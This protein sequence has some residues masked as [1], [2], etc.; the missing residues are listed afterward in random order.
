[1]KIAVIGGGSTYMPELMEG[2]LKH[3]NKMDL[4]EVYLLDLKDSTKFKTVAELCIRMVEKA[5]NPFELKYGYESA[6]ALTDADFI[7]Q[8]YRP[9]L[10]E[11]RINDEKIPLKYSSIGQ[12]T[13]GA[14]GF[15]CGLRG[16]PVV[17]KYIEAIRKWAKPNAKVINF[18]NPSGMISE[19]AIH[20]LEYENFYGLCN[21]PVNMIQGIAESFNT[22]REAV[23][24]RYYG[25][26][27]M[28]WVDGVWVNGE[29]ITG[30]ALKEVYKPEN[31]PE[32]A[33]FEEL[34][35]EMQMILN[36]Y[37]R[38]YYLTRE[39]LKEEIESA[40]EKGTRGEQVREIEKELVAKYSR[41]DLDKKPEE[42]SQRGGSMYS[43]A[44][45][46]L[47][48][49]LC[50]NDNRLHIINTKNNGAV[51]NLP[52]DYVLEIN[53]VVSKDAAKPVTIGKADKRTTGLIHTIKNF[54]RLTIES[55]TQNSTTKAKQALM[56][57]PLAPK[58]KELDE[59]IKDLLDS[60]SKLMKN[61]S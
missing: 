58:G 35:M 31:I 47:I 10:I 5:D 49:D 45:V 53:T 44:A 3:H 20:Y 14:G 56:L 24:L 27:H 15:A 51:E 61:V 33:E 34:A 54:E 17:E 9:G 13:T 40:A 25:L 28:S 50:N 11:G 6:D 22:E 46:E 16:F 37:L 38:Y 59:M 48:R 36:P 42:L 55:Y 39:M 57:H 41:K 26:N 2:L 30:K 7:I 43:T 32:S 4:Q 18:T 21:I 52:S 60:N 12:E 29:D 8:Q 19:F 1:M 23:F